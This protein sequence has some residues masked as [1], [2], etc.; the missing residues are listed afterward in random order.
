MANKKEIKTLK[1]LEYFD[2]FSEDANP[3]DGEYKV[4]SIDIRKEAIKW[5]KILERTYDN[6]SYRDEYIFCVDC[7]KM[8]KVGGT[9]EE[10][11]KERKK[12]N[13]PEDDEEHRTLV[14]ERNYDEPDFDQF[15][16]AIAGLKLFFNITDED[17]KRDALVSGGDE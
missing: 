5:V 1:D 2:C 8:I 9:S 12:H 15:L 11:A 16:G 13:Y 6:S 14:L 10:M 3:N 7:G 4:K 17:L